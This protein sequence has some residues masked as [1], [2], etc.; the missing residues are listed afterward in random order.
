MFD[1]EKLNLYQKIRVVTVEIYKFS[2]ANH[3]ID[4]ILQ[5]Q[6][7][8]S[9]SS[10]MLNLA[11]GTG[12]VSAADKKRFF[13]IAR[14]SVFETVCIIQILYDLKVIEDS[15]YKSWYFKY[16]EISKMLL[17]LKRAY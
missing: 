13:V 6:L 12:R 11:E 17:A 1:F 16:E 10:V 7:K 4:S 3:K 8:R 15:K 9:S 5:D 14:A 2:V